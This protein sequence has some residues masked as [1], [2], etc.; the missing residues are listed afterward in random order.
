MC[1]NFLIAGCTNIE[2]KMDDTPAGLPHPPNRVMCYVCGV[3]Q[4]SSYYRNDTRC[5]FCF[6]PLCRVSKG[7]AYLA[8]NFCKTSMGTGVTKRCTAC[9][10]SVGTGF[11]YCPECGHSL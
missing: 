5:S 3:C 7:E 4:S 10:L 2:V 1:C 9:D 11:R 8:C 6:I